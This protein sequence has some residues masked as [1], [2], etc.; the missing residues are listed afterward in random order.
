MSLGGYLPRR[1]NGSHFT[2][3]GHWS[4]SHRLS[5]DVTQLRSSLFAY[6][7]KTFIASTNVCPVNQ[8]WKHYDRYS[9]GFSYS[10]ELLALSS[11]T[12]MAGTWL[13]GSSLIVFCLYS[14]TFTVQNF[15]YRF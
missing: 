8:S 3:T 6:Q 4:V 11:D 10:A 13:M 9:L 5:V 14:V 15:V 12:R 1:G 2:S 7:V